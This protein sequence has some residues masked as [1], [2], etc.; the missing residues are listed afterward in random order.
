MAEELKLPKVYC[1]N[2]VGTPLR[3]A[4]SGYLVSPKKILR[5][6]EGSHSRSRDPVESRL[7]G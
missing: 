3:L 7:L 4:G 6:S 1:R 5:E 2:F